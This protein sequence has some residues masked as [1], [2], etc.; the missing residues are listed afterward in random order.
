VTDKTILEVMTTTQP[1]CVKDIEDFVKGWKTLT[2]ETEYHN[3]YFTNGSSGK[4]C[5]LL[6]NMWIRDFAT[7][8]VLLTDHGLVFKSMDDATLFKMSCPSQTIVYAD[9]VLDDLDDESWDECTI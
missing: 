4:L 8:T 5:A 7:D 1:C 9:D 3:E 6:A 2:L